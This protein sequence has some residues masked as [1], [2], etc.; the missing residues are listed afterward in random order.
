METMD[1]FS[2]LKSKTRRE[3]LKVLFKKEMHISGI[4]REL[5]ISVPQA[6]KHC[7]QLLEMGLVERRVFGRSH[8]LR[9]R[10]EGLYSIL[11]SFSEETEVDV[12]KG[13]TLIDA[14]EKVAGIKVERADERGFV[15]GIDGEEGYYIYEV[16]G[17]LPNIPMDKFRLN[18]D[19]EVELKK[20]LHIKKK[21]LNIKVREE[22]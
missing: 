17:T 12:K 9:A 5:G 18:E 6:S 21:K 10:R 22:K 14:L 19:S 20:I 1:L 16:N 3:I 7:K 8:V 11:D 4:A 2:V 13:Q 15:T